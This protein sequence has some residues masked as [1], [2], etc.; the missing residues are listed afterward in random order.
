MVDDYDSLLTST[1]CVYEVL[2]GEVFGPGETDV[3]QRRQDFGRVEALEYDETIAIE[4]ANLQAELLDD[5]NPLAQRDAMIAATARS[6][7]DE[8]LV[9]DA[10]FETEALGSYVEVRS[11]VDLRNDGS[12]E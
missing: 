7:G 9:C 3:Y 8:L 6:T 2:V 10:D 11:L 5:G 1:I 4:A 12:S